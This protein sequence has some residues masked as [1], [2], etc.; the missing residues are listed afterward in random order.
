[1]QKY[2]IENII[3]S[4]FNFY[5]NDDLLKGMLISL[6]SEPS[7]EKINVIRSYLKETLTDVPSYVKHHI[8]IRMEMLEDILP[9]TM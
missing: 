5:F 4:S 1:M 8:D 9:Q 6:K 2:D 7:I 3:D